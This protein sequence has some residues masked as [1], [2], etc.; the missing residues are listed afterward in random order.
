[1]GEDGGVYEWVWV[2]GLDGRIDRQPYCMM[3]ERW[4]C[5]SMACFAVFLGTFSFG[6]RQQIEEWS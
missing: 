4:F 3:V 2:G 5:L 1:M 6:K